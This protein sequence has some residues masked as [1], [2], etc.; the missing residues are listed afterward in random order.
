MSELQNVKKLTDSLD[1]LYV[2]DED[3][4]R[5]QM[6]DILKL[7]FNNIYVAKDGKEG[8]ESYKEHRIDMII[9][10]IQMPNINGLDMVEMI[11]KEDPLVP[12]I[13]TTAFNDQKYF[14]KSI[15]LQI[16]KYL[17]K[18]IE[19]KNAIDVFFSIAKMID[20][21]KKAKEFD[22]RVIQNKINRISEQIVSEIANSYQNPCIVFT[23]NKVRYVND[24]L[25]SLFEADEI[26]DFLQD[27]I[28]FDKR[29]GFMLSLNKYDENDP[30]QNRVS[31]S[32]HNGRKIYRV[33]RK[34]IKLD[35]NSEHSTI[36]LFNDITLEEY[37]KIKIKSYT[38]TLEEMVFKTHYKAKATPSK[39]INVEENVSKPDI[40]ITYEEVE[41]DSDQEKEKLTI[42]DNENALLRRS[43]V[44][45]TTAG[46]YI[47]ELDN[48]IL[49]E[50]Q[51]LDE[52]DKDFNDS[53]L[54]LQEDTNVSG[55]QQMS[56]QLERYAHEISLL[57]EFEDLAYAVRSLS[58]LLISVDET[59]L[60]EKIMKKIVLFLAGIQSD[61]A[62][63]RNLIFIEQSAL[64]IHYLD[65]SL[66]SA[67]LQI[68]L[69]LS[70]D[71][72]EMESEDDDLILF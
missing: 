26:D 12:V 46:E 37:Q 16:D 52:L 69:V 47:A 7:F 40:G 13:I 15:D 11:R 27:E 41:S 9:T 24:A 18:P 1:V 30:T 32:K 54:L 36:Y 61:L 68:E 33:V 62:D 14:I 66:F 71:V 58:A 55:I 50:L 8:F 21:R 45:K 28:V 23:D 19:Q 43:H 57:F 2:E 35:E 22:M 48:D 64:D 3:N 25:Y 67:C 17:L 34:S 56:Q 42:N 49:K 44:H 59:R 38:E 29:E 20:D 39:Q 31:I 51:E 65:S 72:E 63:W 5:N 70:D 10:D 4:I 6:L 60:D 53:I